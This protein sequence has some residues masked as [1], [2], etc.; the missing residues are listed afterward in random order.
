MLLARLMSSNVVTVCVLVGLI[1][2]RGDTGGALSMANVASRSSM[3]NVMSDGMSFHTVND[4]SAL[5]TLFQKKGFSRLAG[6]D[7]FGLEP[8]W[9]AEGG[10]GGGGG[11]GENPIEPG[12]GGAGG[13]GRS[14]E[15]FIRG[16]GGG[17]GGG[18]G[19]DG[20]GGD[21]LNVSLPCPSASGGEAGRGIANAIVAGEDA[22]NLRLGE[23]GFSVDETEREIGPLG[24]MEGGG[25]GAV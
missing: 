22:A 9:N 20:R 14:D 15:P 18:G 25:G 13:G 11:G 5:L 12:G 23:S 19:G 4:T 10:G 2:R 16:S 8:I 3:L 24:F 21:M 1:L 6:R 7:I 17:G